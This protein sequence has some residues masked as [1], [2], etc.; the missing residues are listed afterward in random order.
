MKASSTIRTYCSLKNLMAFLLLIVS[1]QLHAQIPGGVATTIYTPM[2]QPVFAIVN[3]EDAYYRDY[4]NNDNIQR[5]NQHGWWVQ[6]ESGATT[7]SQCHGWA[8]SQYNGGPAVEIN[9]DVRKYFT[10]DAVEEIAP[11]T[12]EN[13]EEGVMIVFGANMS[14]PVH[15]AITTAEYGIVRSKWWYGAVYRHTLDGHPWG[16]S[17]WQR[18]WYRVK[19]N[20]DQRVCAFGSTPGYS[21]TS[22]IPGATYSWKL[23]GAPVGGNSSAV[24]I[25]HNFS[26]N[27][28]KT[29]SV[30]IHCPLS[31]TTIKSFRKICFGENSGYV[32]GG[33]YYIMGSMN[34]TNLCPYTSYTL[35][36]SPPC[37]ASGFTYTLP[38][39]FTINS[40]S[41]F[42]LSFS[43]GAGGSGSIEVHANVWCSVSASRCCVPAPGSNVLIAYAYVD[44]YSTSCGWSLTVSPNP[45]ADYIDI[46]TGGDERQDAATGEVLFGPAPAKNVSGDV[47]ESYLL[48]VYNSQQVSVFTTKSRDRK[49]TV[50][51]RQMQNGIYIA[52]IIRGKERI[53]RRFAVDH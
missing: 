37:S 38:P 46:E 47:G 32:S 10:N 7:T 41:D 28:N 27:T 39:G 36:V 14:V 33:S 52:E 4:V 1:V 16:E 40:A 9:G 6:V 31:G 23:S 18:G 48:T 17:N 12:Q 44:T 20:G 24:S 26:P 13:W 3:P 21:T 45:A 43:T 11:L 49:V 19:M 50:S 15:T 35:Y 25:Y 8:W 34:N 5:I 42:S 30:E 29:L 53:T 2:G 22:A 51:T